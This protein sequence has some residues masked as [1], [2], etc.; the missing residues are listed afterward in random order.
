M[1][2]RIQSEQDLALRVIGRCFGTLVAKKLTA[3]I[4]SRRV[5]IDDAILVCLSAILDTESRETMSLL[6]RTGAI[7]LA[8]IISL[9]LVDTD[10]LVGDVMLSDVL[11]VFKQT[12][13]ILSKSLLSQGHGDLSAPQV[14]QFHEMYSNSPHWVKC[15]L[16]E[17]SVWL[18]P[19][20]SYAQRER[21][22]ELTQG[23]WTN[24]SHVSQQS[25]EIQVR[26]GEAPDSG[27][28]DGLA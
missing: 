9:M 12:L 7:E 11:D 2:H 3:D 18:P 21:D 23:S 14:A 24:I 5:Q 19:I 17:V 25:R 28:G 22:Y 10:T 8:S 15:E 1:T 20:S 4:K 6:G 26:I 13:Q 27:F 16:Q